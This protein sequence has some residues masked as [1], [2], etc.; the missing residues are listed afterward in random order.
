MRTPLPSVYVEP[1][2]KCFGLSRLEWVN[3]ELVL[4]E[5]NVVFIV[6][7]I[8]RNIHPN[9][10]VDQNLFGH[11]DVGVVILES[12]VHFAVHST[13][14]FLLWRWPLWN[15]MLKGASLHDHK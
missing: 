7:G 12:L 6:E 3:L 5:D 13:R 15:V 4:L 10:Y 2:V 8:C 9:D 11:E 1:I 14:R